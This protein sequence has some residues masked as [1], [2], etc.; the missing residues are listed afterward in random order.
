MICYSHSL[1]YPNLHSLLLVPTPS[2]SY[3]LPNVLPTLT[4]R[5]AGLPCFGPSKMAARLEGSKAF[6]KDFMK[7]HHIPTADYAV[8]VQGGWAGLWLVGGWVGG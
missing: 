5:A 3:P 2:Y 7:R 6:A 4:H 8:R 1:T